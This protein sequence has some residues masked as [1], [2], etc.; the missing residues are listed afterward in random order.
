M[1]DAID[2][3]VGRLVAGLK[4]TGQYENTLIVFTSDQGIAFGQH[5]FRVKL[6]PYDANI[7]SPMIVS[8]PA[9]LPSGK[10]CPHPVSGVDLP[11]T[12][13]SFAGIDLA[14]APARH[15]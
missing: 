11:P 15:V 7:R 14:G 10:V 8:M 4:E 6:A 13:F 12:F 1:F 3:A 9:R 2:D 5:G